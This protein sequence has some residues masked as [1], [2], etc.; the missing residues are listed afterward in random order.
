MAGIES[1]IA[2]VFVKRQH[3]TSNLNCFRTIA[4]C[5]QIKQLAKEAQAHAVLRTPETFGA[6]TLIIDQLNFRQSV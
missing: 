4:F 5:I 1:Y 3:T 6:A 2:K